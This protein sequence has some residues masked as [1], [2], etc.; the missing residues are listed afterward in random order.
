MKVTSMT[1]VMD[2][3]CHGRLDTYYLQ[4]CLQLR[5]VNTL[6]VMIEDLPEEVQFESTNE[7]V[8][9]NDTNNNSTISSKVTVV[10]LNGS[11]PLMF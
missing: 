9:K 11:F 6:E 5:D 2:D 8:N 3:F 10:E 1:S 4:I 7:P